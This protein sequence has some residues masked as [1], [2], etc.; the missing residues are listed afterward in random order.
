MDLSTYYLGL[1]LKCPVIAG[2]SGWTGSVD[3]IRALEDNGVGA[4]VLKSLF[5]EQIL[6]ELEVNLEGYS[7]DYPGSTDYIRGYTR[8]NALEKYLNLVADAKK[9]VDI[10]VVASI[11]CIS[12]NEWIS[13]ASEIEKAGAAAIEL[14]VSMLP[15]DPQQSCAEAEK[16]YIE[17]VEKVAGAVSV[18]L[19]LKMSLFSSGLAH[20]ITNLGWEKGVA[21]F[22]LFNRYYRPDIDIDKMCF[23]AAG[24]LSVEQEMYETLRW[25]ALLA[26]RVEKDFIAGTGIHDSAGLIKQLLVGATAV[27]IVSTLYNNG[28][29]HVQT[30]LSGLERWM[31]EKSF[32][33]L[34]DFRGTLGYAKSDNP[35]FFERSQFMRYYGGIK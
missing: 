6:A 24:R 7:R 19:V 15:F 32:E 12:G 3:K 2:S 9:A 25:T 5:E 28:M 11:N 1:S 8:D 26:S 21:G 20:L 33:R 14:N 23:T 31:E 13:F 17:T 27:Q 29:S 30:M 18:P 10:P 22:V 35:T 4:V 16:K 34:E